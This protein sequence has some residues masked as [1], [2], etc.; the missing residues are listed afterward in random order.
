MTMVPFGAF[1]APAGFA[2]HVWSLAVPDGWGTW[3]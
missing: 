3:P 2:V 1:L